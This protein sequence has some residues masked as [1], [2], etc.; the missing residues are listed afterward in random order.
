MSEY[1]DIDQWAKSY[2]PEK[3]GFDPGPELLED[4]TYS[5]EITGAE[6][7]QVGKDQ[8]KETVLK[9]KL[10]VL[11]GTHTG[12]ELTR[13]TFFRKQRDSD[14][15]GADLLTLGYQWDGTGAQLAATC[16]MLKG[17]RFQGRKRS[18]DKKD[19]RGQP[20]GEKGHDVE[21][22][23]AIRNA[24][25]PSRPTAMPVNNHTPELETADSPY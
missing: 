5:F 7:T 15:L 24:P 10:K 20:N 17:L 12:A 23:S 8:Q 19:H 18:W 2:K 9:L 6:L 1:A 16:P 13:T 3:S 22:S 21:V 14:N 4:G 11:S 25:M